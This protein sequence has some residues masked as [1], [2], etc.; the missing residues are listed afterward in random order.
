MKLR[1]LTIAL[2]AAL[3]APIGGFAQDEFMD[4]EARK[5]AR[6]AKKEKA[7]RAKRNKNFWKINPRVFDTNKNMLIEEE[8]IEA[9]MPEILEKIKQAQELILKAFDEDGDGA[10]GE[11][12][13]QTMN[14]LIKAVQ[15]LTGLRKYDKDKDLELSEEEIEGVKAMML[16]N[17]EKQNKK[18]LARFDTDNDGIISDAEIQDAKQRR[19]ELRNKQ[20]GKPKREKAG[21]KK[22]A[23]KDAWKPDPNVP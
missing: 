21:R 4:K 22:G 12:E 2:S 18:M 11:E 9:G 8:E 14:E 13:K 10:I 15:A 23:K 6:K 7:Q 17:A 20:G 19:K 3:L 1:I 5:K 16:S